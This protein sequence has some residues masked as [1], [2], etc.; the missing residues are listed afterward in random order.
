MTDKK[1]I[2]VVILAGGFGTR[3]SEESQFKPKPMIEIGDKPILWHIMK[4][5][6]AY[7]FNDFIILGGYKQYIIKE[8]FADYF[9][10]NADVS[11]D[12]ANN[13]MQVLDGHAEKWKVAVID[14]GLNTQ[15]GGRVKRIKKYINNKFMLTYGDGVCNVNLDELL[16]FHENHKKIMTMTMINIAQNKGVISFDNASGKINSFREKANEDGVVINGGFMVCEPE[17]FDYLKDDSSILEQEPMRDLVNKGE[18][19]GYLHNGFW[20]CMDTQRE[21]EKLEKLW[22]SG[23][24]PWKIWE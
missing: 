8:F 20:Q 13:S 19:M 21:K 18:L 15:T 6:S 2:K 10:H 7:G 3:I 22:A 16:K 23:E 4:F 17:L 5:Y 24:A 11:F 9:L 14:T 1:D 12:L